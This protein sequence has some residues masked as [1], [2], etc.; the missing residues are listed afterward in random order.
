M[1][2]QVSNEK[3]TIK[4]C[5]YCHV[6]K[7]QINN[8]NQ[9]IHQE[10]FFVIYAGCLMYLY[11]HL[12]IIHLFV[13]LLAFNQREIEAHEYIHININIHKFIAKCT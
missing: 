11:G 3:K 1:N 6:D 12:F 2:V 13:K 10:R 5:L 4:K 9:P 7:F 8:G